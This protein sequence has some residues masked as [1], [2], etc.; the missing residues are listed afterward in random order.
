MTDETYGRGQVELALWSN[1]VG[2]QKSSAK[3]IPKI[4]KARIKHLIDIDKGKI[5]EKGKGKSIDF[6]K[7]EVPPEAKY[8]F[9]PPAGENAEVAYSGCD[10]FSL[11]V[12]LDLLNIGFKQ[13]E[14]VITMRYLRPELDRRYPGLLG[15]P[16]LLVRQQYPAEGFPELPFYMDG[17]TRIADPRLFMILSKVELTEILPG[18]FQKSKKDPVIFA[19]DFCEGIDKL[20]DRLHGT[21]PLARRAVTVLELAWN[22]QSVTDYL[23][24]G[25]EIGR[26]RNKA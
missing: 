15:E 5:K 13:T 19:P 11:A 12:G 17:H 2:K 26:G 25:P 18:G 7:F 22:A 8:V 4:F 16:S 9:A 3:D 23:E 1:F 20:R 21:M 6:S 24:K 10:A 14:V